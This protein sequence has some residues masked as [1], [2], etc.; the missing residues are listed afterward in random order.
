MLRIKQ[1]YLNLLEANP[2]NLPRR[3]AYG[4]LCL[5]S[6]LY[7]LAVYLRNFFYDWGIFPSWW[8]QSKV[9]SV[10]NISWA[11]SGKT[12]LVIWLREQFCQQFK[13]AI[14]RRGY[15]EDEGKL[16]LEAGSKVFSSPDR[17]GLARKLDSDFELFILDDGFQYRR[18][19]RTVD[20]VVMGAR[21]FRNKPRLI[22]AWIFREPLS[23]LKR[24]D[25]IVVNYSDELFDRAQISDLI[26][27][28]SPQS[29]LFFS[30]YQVKG[31]FDLAAN[32][33]DL[34]WLKGKETAAFTA[35]GYPEGFFNKLQQSGLD[36]SRKI[37]YP[38][39]YQLKAAEYLKLEDGLLSAGISDLIITAKDKYHFP[40]GEKRLNIIVM[41]ITVEIENSKGFI[42]VLQ[43]KLA[44]K[45]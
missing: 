19:K 35:I 11:G 24:A 37:V 40:L 5:L 39:H 17:L 18:L 26:N 29:R 38:D 8:A 12:S 7:W 16:L 14:L 42:E 30:G 34:N 6:G 9:I 32:P 4:F 44:G 2:R 27:K 23:S 28:F 3:I 21:E 13:T 36:I 10:G 41:E 45:L 22:P 31:F 1:S 33:V 25:I 20:L 15:G 43:T